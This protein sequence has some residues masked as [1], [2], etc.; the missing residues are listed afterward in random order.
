MRSYQVRKKDVKSIVNATFPGYRGRKIRLVGIEEVILSNINWEGGSR[1]Q[2]R[3]CTLDGEPTGDMDAFNAMAPWS[4]NAEN[5][6]VSIPAGYAVVEHVQ[7]CGKDLGLRI[8]VH[9]NS[10]RP[11]LER[12]ES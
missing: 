10:L 7:F 4:H 3:A 6:R 11:L 2:Y 12:I 8:H 5:A 1:S 9:P